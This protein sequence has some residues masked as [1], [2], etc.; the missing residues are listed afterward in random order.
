MAGSCCN[1]EWIRPKT[2]HRRDTISYRSPFLLQTF[3]MP[4][5]L[6]LSLF[7]HLF[8]PP[9]TSTSKHSVYIRKG[10]DFAVH[11]CLLGTAQQIIF[12]VYMRPAGTGD[13][14]IDV[15]LFGLRSV[16]RGMVA[17]HRSRSWGAVMLQIC[18]P[19]CLSVSYTYRLSP[20]SFISLSV[21]HFS[22]LHLLYFT[23]GSIQERKRFYT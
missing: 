21:S 23:P 1:Q 18:P 14:W 5:A 2:A 3:N 19:A 12:L 20:R 10:W 8:H 11:T 15:L 7:F 9:H 13:C 6:L 4:Y 17:K 22:P 16:L